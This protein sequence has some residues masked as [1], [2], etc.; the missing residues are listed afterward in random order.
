MVWK[1]K[2]VLY[3]VSEVADLLSV[4]VDTVYTLVQIKELQAHNRAP[5]QKGMRITGKSIEG[6][7]ERHLVD[8][9]DYFEVQA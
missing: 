7:I 5:G 1:S 8:V 2:K 6:Y 4:H 9:D 3:R